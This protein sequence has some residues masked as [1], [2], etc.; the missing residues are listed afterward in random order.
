M[1]GRGRGSGTQGESSSSSEVSKNSGGISWMSTFS[2]QGG[3]IMPVSVSLILAEL[4][5]GVARGGGNG[6]GRR[7]WRGEGINYYS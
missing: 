2:F 4:S 5:S 6:K 1:S 3:S 7:E